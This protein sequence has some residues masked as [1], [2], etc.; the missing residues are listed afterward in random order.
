MRVGFMTYDRKINFYNIKGNLSQPQQMTVGDVGDMFV[1]LVDGFMCNV[2]ESEA[3]IDRYFFF[4]KSQLTNYGSKFF[5]RE[6]A[7]TSTGS[8]ITPILKFI[9][10]LSL[11]S[12]MEQ[13]PLMFGETRET[14]TVLGPVIQAGKEAFKV[15][16]VIFVN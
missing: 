4:V 12:L 13:I 1:P 8:K 16:I 10:V 2:E 3:V 6:I 14:E 15:S 11:Y 5:S 7:S 9:F